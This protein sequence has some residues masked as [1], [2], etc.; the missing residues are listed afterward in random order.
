MHHD[1]NCLCMHYYCIVLFRICLY[2]KTPQAALGWD[3]YF[4]PFSATSWFILLGIMLVAAMLMALPNY[5]V[6]GT[7]YNENYSC[8][9]A[10]F[11]TLTSMFQQGNSRKF[12]CYF[13]TLNINWKVMS[14]QAW[15]RN[16]SHLQEGQHSSQYS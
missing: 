10:F 2:I 3:T 1:C 5:V 7:S 15:M 13:E 8:C 9:L 14:Y 12:E 16:Q 11:V 6:E 4:D